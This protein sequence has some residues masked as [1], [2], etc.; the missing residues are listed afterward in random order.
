MSTMTTFVDLDSSMTKCACGATL[1][2][3]DG[4]SEAYIENWM[5]AHKTHCDTKTEVVTDDGT[6]CLAYHPG[7]VT[8]A[9][10]PQQKT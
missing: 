2:V 1:V 5:K 3:D 4:T 7:P 10:N 8:T 9:M 6:R